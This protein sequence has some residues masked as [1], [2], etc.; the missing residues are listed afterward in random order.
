MSNG[1]ARPRPI[2][3]SVAELQRSTH[4]VD[5]DFAPVLK[6]FLDYRRSV[7]GKYGGVSSAAKPISN[8]VVEEDD[9]ID[10]TQAFESQS[11]KGKKRPSE[12]YPE[13]TPPPKVAK[14]E[15]TPVPPAG[16]REGGQRTW[17]PTLPACAASNYRY[18]P[19]GLSAPQDLKNPFYS[20]SLKGWTQCRCILCSNW[21]TATEQGDS[22]NLRSNLPGALAKDSASPPGYK[23]RFL[24]ICTNCQPSLAEEL[25]SNPQ[26]Y[27]G[28]GVCYWIMPF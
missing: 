24:P 25:R 22:R 7:K 11:S 21:L 4:K 10:P 28:R 20:Q 12:D 18:D 3:I 13:G 5:L 16:G 1:Y 14:V 23:T 17:R 2:G 27:N 26:M 9:S 15:E 19:D 6:A 8:P